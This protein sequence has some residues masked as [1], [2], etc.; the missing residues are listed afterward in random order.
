MSTSANKAVGQ[1]KNGDLVSASG[2]EGNG[3]IQLWDTNSWTVKKTISS[4]GDVFNVLAVLPNN[5]VAINSGNNIKIWNVIDGYLRRSLIGHTSFVSCLIVMPNG[6][7]ASGAWDYKVIIWNL[8]NGS[9][10]RTLTGHTFWVYA[11]T[12]SYHINGWNLVSG[13]A[14][15]IIKV[16]DVN[17]GNEKASVLGHT[18]IVYALG[19]QNSSSYLFSSSADKTLKVWSIYAYFT[20]KVLNG[21]IYTA[22]I[23]TLVSSINLRALGFS[24]ESIRAFAVLPDGSVASATE[25]SLI[26]WNKYFGFVKSYS[27]SNGQFSML[28]VLN[29]GDLISGMEY[30]TQMIVWNYV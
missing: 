19:F 21:P 23:T 10:R 4:P 28:L 6:D 16:W 22:F 20:I 15:K 17:T 1:L 3:M 13:S 5:D 11:L 25:N 30:S 18:D 29:N 12:I 14:D 26:F 7:L 24:F 2:Y 8:D 27:N 9:I